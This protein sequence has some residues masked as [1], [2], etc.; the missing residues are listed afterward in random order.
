M[1]DFF[2]DSRG[3]GPSPVN[4]RFRSWRS[5][6]NLRRTSGI[7]TRTG[8]PAGGQGAVQG[9]HEVVAGSQCVRQDGPGR[10]GG[11]GNDCRGHRRD[12]GQRGHSHRR[13]AKRTWSAVVLTVD[14]SRP[15]ASVYRV[16]V[17]PRRRAAVFIRATNRP[18]CRRPSVRVSR[19]C[20]RPTEE[21]A[22]SA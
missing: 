20:Y 1:A 13:H 4:W 11:H 2:T 9:E 18:G 14:E 15:E 7:M 5:G 22:S 10:T 19:P 3:R 17:M 8:L 16:P 12:R 21:A 6:W